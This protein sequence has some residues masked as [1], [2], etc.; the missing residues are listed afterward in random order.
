MEAIADLA[1]VA[2]GSVFFHARSKAA[3]LNQVFQIDMV[4]WVDDAF[5]QPGCPDVLEDLVRRYAWLQTAMCAQPDLT[6]MYMREMAFATDEDERATEAVSTLLERTQEIIDKG[7]QNGQLVTSVDSHQV[8]ANLF[9]IYFMQQLA[10]LSHPQPP[11]AS[12]CDHLRP[13]FAAQIEP[14]LV[15]DRHSA[16]SLTAVNIAFTTGATWGVG[17]MTLDDIDLLDL[18]RFRRSSTTRCSSSLR[19]R[20]RCTGTDEPDGPVSGTS[21]KYADLVTSTAT[22]GFS[23]EVGGINIFDL[24]ERAR[25]SDMRAR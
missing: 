11:G 20:S 19:P 3:L 25:R 13:G 17:T 9:A 1:G 15:R 5:E 24:D 4:R 23:S 7:A 8:A 6:S 16:D 2:K 18:D 14:L 22:R 12:S 10:W 21:C